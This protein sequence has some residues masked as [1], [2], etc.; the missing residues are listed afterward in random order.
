M[1]WLQERNRN[2]LYDAL[3]EGLVPRRTGLI[4]KGLIGVRWRVPSKST[5][6]TQHVVDDVQHWDGR[7]ETACDCQW[8][9]EHGPFG[10]PTHPTPCRH[11]LIVWFYMLAA[12]DRRD[13]L[14]RDRGLRYAFLR[15]ARKNQIAV[16][17]PD[18]DG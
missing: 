5:P 18:E 4:G 3:Q 15:G 13:L 16:F 2:K 6:G 8:A 1:D 12:V 11:V 14:K 9:D 7:R 10:D 17:F